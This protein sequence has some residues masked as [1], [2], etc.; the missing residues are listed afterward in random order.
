MDPERPIEK[1]LR[2]AAQ[3]RR[4][5]AGAPQELHPA[6][7]RMLQSEVARKFASG[8][9]RERGSFF[10]LFMPRLAWAAAL[11]VGLGLAA[12]LMLP[13]KN[14]PQQEMLFAKNDRLATVA[15]ANE[16][17]A[18]LAAP[19]EK[20]APVAPQPDSSAL[21]QANSQRLAD[22]ERDK[23]SLSVGRRT[24]ESERRQPL[25]MNEPAAAPVTPAPKL[26]AHGVGDGAARQLAETQL[27]SVTAA[28]DGSLAK[29][30]QKEQL[31]D[32]YTA[33]PP[34]TPVTQEGSSQRRYR[35]ARP[36]QTAPSTAPAGAAGVGANSATKPSDET[37]KSELA[38]KSMPTAAAPASASLGVQL[39][40]ANSA[41]VAK[42]SP[43]L[44]AQATQKFV[45]TSLN[46]AFDLSDRS[47]GAQP[48]LF[49]FELQQV[50][51]TVQ[52]VDSDGSV[53]SG[54]FQP[55][56]TF[57]YLNSTVSEQAAVTRSL[58]TAEAQS[59]RKDAVSD[60]KLQIDMSYPFKVTGTNLSS[61]QIVTFTGQILAPTNAL[62]PLA[63]A[64]TVNGNRVAPPEFNPLPLQNS[65]IA[66]K[67]LIGTNKEVEVN[68]VPFH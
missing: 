27:H 30:K 15:S 62:S 54:S 51:R 19:S 61:K 20:V 12:S 64:G 11:I 46:K 43:A 60:S 28:A 31:A 6:T 57:D 36:A 38:Y 63:P 35:L 42:R 50:G 17:K 34:Q 14:V 18:R 23:D 37:A 44:V 55:S 26:E 2:Q 68:A 52:I 1:L 22:A 25:A 10:E 45:Q 32:A 4:D 3:A 8:A 13:R 40:S 7:R 53:Y 65:R 21:A 49:S 33:A 47:A 29:E 41:D 24:L 16:S 5:Q 39:K 56:Q 9:P 59:K 48:I 58:Q 66:G 67:A